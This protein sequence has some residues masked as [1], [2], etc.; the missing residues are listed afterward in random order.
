MHYLTSEVGISW[1]IKLSLIKL[2]LSLI[3]DSLSKM[4]IALPLSAGLMTMSLLF[5]KDLTAL[6][7][8]FVRFFFLGSL[9][10]CLCKSCSIEQNMD[11]SWNGPPALKDHLSLKALCS[12]GTPGWVSFPGGS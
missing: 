12:K 2:F 9:Y 5:F 8:S 11:S 10:F 6:Y 3:Y 4:T 1:F 7:S